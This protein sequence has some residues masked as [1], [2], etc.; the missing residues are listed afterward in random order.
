M[1]TSIDL[2]DPSTLAEL[3][4]L[5]A[6]LREFSTFKSLKRS[7]WFKRC[8]TRLDVLL[9]YPHIENHVL[10]HRSERE[11]IRCV[12]WN[13]E[14]GKRFEGLVKA[15]ATDSRLSGADV[16]CLQEADA[17]MSR[18]RNRFVALELAHV[19]KMNFAF[20]PCWIEL[21]PGVGEDRE[22]PG[23]NTWSLQGNAI[24][25]RFPIKSAKM[26]RLPQCFEPFDFEEKRYGARNAVI[27]VLDLGSKVLKVVCTH[28]EVRN[29]PGCRARQMTALLHS[30]EAGSDQPILIAGDF[31]SN[32]F[33]RGTSWRTLC[34]Y[35]RLT[36]TNPQRLVTSTLNPQSRE[37]LFE[38]LRESGFQW[39]PFNDH[40][41][42]GG[43]YLRSLEDVRFIPGFLAN[44]AMK[45]VD[46]FK[47]GL[48]LRLDWFVTKNLSPASTPSAGEDSERSPRPLPPTTV[49]ILEDGTW[50]ETIADHRPILVDLSLAD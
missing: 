6:H 35:L 40:R 15:F 2:T 37:P 16:I 43:T 3:T 45:A 29:T 30:L 38:G 17:G 11:W 33:A 1:P 10:E 41:A 27:C 9:S 25:S 28:L 32:T 44:H 12:S 23:G 39:E 22:V 26:V 8:K 20:A 36:M 5:I 50:V 47:D 46:R 18:S 19:L 7:E 31:N 14:K 42:T 4:D 48:P 21:T 24:L 49:D 13:I 34:G